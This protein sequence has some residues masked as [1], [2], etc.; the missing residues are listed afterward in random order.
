[1]VAASPYSTIIV[2][3]LRVDC[4]CVC[5]CVCDHGTYTL[6]CDDELLRVS[7]LYRYDIDILRHR[8]KFYCIRNVCVCVC[9]Y[10]SGWMYKDF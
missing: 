6:L 8:V 7:R 4:V 2:Y 10:A 9:V 1:V 3:G 5:V